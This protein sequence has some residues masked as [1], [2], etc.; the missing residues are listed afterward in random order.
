MRGQGFKST[1]GFVVDT[2]FGKLGHLLGIFR[3]RE[4]E[5][6]RASLAQSQLARPA[7]GHGAGFQ[8]P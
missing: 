8:Q 7:V 6:P 2:G 3:R 1:P 4:R 5:I